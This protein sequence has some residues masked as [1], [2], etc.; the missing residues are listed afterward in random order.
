METYRSADLWINPDRGVKLFPRRPDSQ[1]RTMARSPREPSLTAQLRMMLQMAGSR[2]VPWVSS[3]VGLSILLALLDTLGVAAMVP[4]TQLLTGTAPDS[5]AL[6]AISDFFGTT[7]P[8]F[9]I[10]AVAGIVTA[11]FVVKSCAA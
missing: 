2:P 4:L 7:D 11:L 6:G 1:R 5:G 3:T 8:S 9:L 10:P